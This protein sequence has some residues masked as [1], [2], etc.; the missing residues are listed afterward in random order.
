MER[1]GFLLSDSAPE[2]FEYVHGVLF[3][4]L[5]KCMKTAIEWKSAERRLYFKI[6]NNSD[7]I[8]AIHAKEPGNK[9]GYVFLCNDCFSDQYLIHSWSSDFHEDLL[10]CVACEKDVGIDE[11]D[12]RNSVKKIGYFVI[13]NDDQLVTDLHAPCTM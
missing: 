3:K 11:I 8:G 2:K 1:Y 6:L 5:Y 10:D 7:I 12:F 4:N 13:L 9:Y